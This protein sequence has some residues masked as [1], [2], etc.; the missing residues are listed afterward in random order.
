MQKSLDR[1]HSQRRFSF[2]LSDLI[3]PIHFTAILF[4]MRFWLAV[5]AGNSRVRVWPITGWKLADRKAAALFLSSNEFWKPP[6]AESDFGEKISAASE[7]VTFFS[8]SARLEGITREMKG[9]YCC[10]MFPLLGTENTLFV[11]SRL[12]ASSANGGES[13]AK[14]RLHDEKEVINRS[15]Y[16]IARRS[17]TQLLN[18]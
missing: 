6:V 7:L 5:D 15:A 3:F 13:K 14:A 16:K 4:C 8:I 1:F 10:V 12:R 17:R 11:I 9:C 2:T 18:L